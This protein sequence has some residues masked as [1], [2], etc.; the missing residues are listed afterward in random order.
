MLINNI[1]TTTLTTLTTIFQ[2]ALAENEMLFQRWR[3]EELAMWIYAS[4]VDLFAVNKFL[5]VFH[6][7]IARKTKL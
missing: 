6:V 1:D 7:S 2:S 5:T 4:P 3:R